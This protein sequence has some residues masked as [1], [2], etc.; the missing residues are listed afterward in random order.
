MQVFNNAVF[1]DLG[2][3]M[4]PSPKENI[5]QGRNFSGSGQLV[6]RNLFFRKA[7]FP[8]PRHTYDLVILHRTLAEMESHEQRVALVEQLWKRTNK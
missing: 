2:T 4:R 7:L 3:L 5:F 8:S 6:S 1:F